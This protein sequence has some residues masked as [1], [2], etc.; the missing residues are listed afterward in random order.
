VRNPAER[1]QRFWKNDNLSQ[2]V[3]SCRRMPWFGAYYLSI[4]FKTHIPV[5]AVTMMDVAFDTSWPS[6]SVEFCPNDPRSIFVCGTYKLD[7]PPDEVETRKQ[8]R[9]GKCLVF[10]VV[11]SGGEHM[12][13]ATQFKGLRQISRVYADAN[14]RKFHCLQFLT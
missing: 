10:E 9:R 5:T 1:E 4:K 2:F 11:S 8:H 3:K 12:Y 14:F 13:V 6:D 7:Q